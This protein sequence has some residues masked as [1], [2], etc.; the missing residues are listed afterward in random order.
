MDNREERNKYPKISEKYRIEYIG[1]EDK[2]REKKRTIYR[3]RHWYNLKLWWDEKGRYLLRTIFRAVFII[4]IVAFFIWGIV[5]NKP[6][7]TSTNN[8]NP[9]ILERNFPIL[10][11]P[12]SITF[13][14]GYE[15]KTYTITETLYK[16][17][18]EYYNSA[19][20]EYICSEGYC[21]DDWK[22][23]YVKMF[24]KKA[25]GDN[26]ISQVASDIETVGQKAKLSDDQIIELTIAF[27]QSI[28]YDYDKVKTAEFFPRYPY[29][30]LYD[31]K[32]IC[33]G[34]SFLAVLLMKEMDYGVAL[35]DFDYEKHIAPAVKCP[36]EYS[37]Y[38]SGYCFAEVTGL[39]F[40][41]GEIPQMDISSGKPET[42]TTIELFSEEKESEL[43]WSELKNVEIYE[44]TD[45]NSYQGIIK[46]AQTIQRIETL[47]KE[48]NKLKGVIILLKN[49]V[50][51]L[52]SSVSYYDQ[53]AKAAYR[54][55][56]IFEGHTSYNE[57]M[58]LY[59]Q[60]KSVYEKY[61][62]KLNEYNR[63][64]DKYNNLAYEYNA[65]IEDF[66]K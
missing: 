37:S 26:T 62:S 18:F 60:Y 58:R 30:V 19:P 14:W 34:K 48:S 39:G 43:T 1:P 5:S 36:K 56:E 55:H 65:L 27:V 16:T 11:E 46:T 40:R 33:S 52:K 23:D 21:P 53:E 63:K 6:A 45:G 15:G 3:V 47:E 66:Y 17:A 32:G 35:F 57:Y 13:E 22:D 2:Q 41:V 61:E 31:N 20:K 25:E 28:P 9:N 54:R 59:S 38:N 64:V 12:R 4:G 24:L 49:E 50:D 29:E 7:D 42:R 8:V 51:E 10:Q 44:I